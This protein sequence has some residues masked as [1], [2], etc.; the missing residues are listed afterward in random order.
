MAWR[1]AESLK[2]LR[3]QINAAYPNRDKASD[4]G[5]GD[6]RHASRN[7]DHNPWVKDRNGFGV[8]TAIDID[9]DLAPDIHSIEKIVKAIQASRDPRVKYIIYEGRITV[10]GDITQ[11]KPYHG[12]NPHQHHV[13]ISVKSDPKFYDSTAAWHIGTHEVT[14]E[15]VGARIDAQI[16]QPSP[17]AAQP[18]EPTPIEHSSGDVN[19][20]DS[21]DAESGQNQSA[22]QPATLDPPA[23]TSAQDVTV[24]DKSTWFGTKLGGIVSGI[25]TGAY[26]IP[27]FN[28]SEGQMELI[29]LILP[30]IVIGLPLTLAVW[31]AVKKWHLIE[32]AKL[33]VT[34]NTSPHTAKMVWDEPRGASQ[35][36]SFVGAYA[37]TLIIVLMVGIAAKAM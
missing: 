11:W 37:W 28:L 9:E 35:L 8:V 19:S 24:T 15:N 3:L 29:K 20:T 25:F 16:K 10:P 33:Y 1:I 23:N 27:Q 6:A 5:I 17:V 18:L 34:T 4:G 30:Y 14:P 32:K 26:V 12:I 36:T 31:Y 21:H 7:S 22:G 2:T 13:H